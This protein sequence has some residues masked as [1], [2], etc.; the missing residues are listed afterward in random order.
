MT[1]AEHAG[2]RGLEYRS[3]V[4]GGTNSPYYAFFKALIDFLCYPIRLF[5]A[6]GRLGGTVALVLGVG[7]HYAGWWVATT[8]SVWGLGVSGVG[9]AYC[10]YGVSRFVGQEAR[11]RQE[12]AAT[13]PGP[14]SRSKQE[15]ELVLQT[16]PLPFFVC[17]RCRVVMT[18]AECGGKCQKCGS[19]ADCLPVYAEA[20]RVTAKSG[21]Y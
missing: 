13:G 16:R 3:L 17:T 21:L 10:V 11:L 8:T 20:D 14:V 5:D 12:Y 18:P 1:R 6:H 4:L 15:L 7:M 19:E 2:A 9:V